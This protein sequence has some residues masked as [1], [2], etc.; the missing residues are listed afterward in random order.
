M[1]LYEGLRQSHCS[2][3][4]QN[5]VLL[6]LLQGQLLLRLLVLM[7]E[8]LLLHSECHGV[9]MFYS[10]FFCLWILTVFCFV[11][12]SGDHTVKI[13]DCETGNCLKVL[14]GHR[15]TPWVVS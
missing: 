2:I 11:L 6:E 9:H 4:L 10:L 15:R 3:Y 7:E 8:L 5:I 14:T 13:I 1:I 12:C